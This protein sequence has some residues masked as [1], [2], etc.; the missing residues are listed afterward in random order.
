MSCAGKEF[1]LFPSAGKHSTGA[2]FGKTI[3]WGNA[4]EKNSTCF[5]ARE[6]IQLVPSGGKQL[7][8][9]MYGKRIQRVSKRRK[10]PS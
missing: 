8:D 4:R 9:V 2:K 5:Q 6:N 1:N 10:H 3:S 7:G